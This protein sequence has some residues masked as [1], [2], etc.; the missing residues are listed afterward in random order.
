MV[1]GVRGLWEGGEARISCGKTEEESRI[2]VLVG[3]CGGGADL[4]WK[5]LADAARYCGDGGVVGY[6]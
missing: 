3:G 2:L 5:D 4:R 1:G 6:D